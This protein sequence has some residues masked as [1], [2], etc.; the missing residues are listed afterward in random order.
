MSVIINPDATMIN[1][2]TSEDL[3]NS[4]KIVTQPLS[5]D[6]IILMWQNGVQRVGDA[7]ILLDRDNHTGVQNSETVTY[8]APFTGAQLQT[9]QQFNDSVYLSNIDYDKT[10]TVGAS[11]ADF[12]TINA[13]LNELSRYKQI[14]VKTNDVSNNK[15]KILL[16]S[17]FVAAEQININSVDF[18]WVDIVSEDAEVV[19]SRA[20]LTTKIGRWYPFIRC[21]SGTIPSIKTLFSM[22]G[23]GTATERVALY[24]INAVGF[25]ESG[26]GFKNSGERN[27]DITQC[28]VLNCSSGIFTGAGV[29]NFRPATGS[30]VFMQ[31]A[32]VSGSVTGMSCSTGAVVAAENLVATNCSDTAV[33]VQG[34]VSI[35]LTSANLSNAGVY[36]LRAYSA[37]NTNA[38]GLTANNCA[39]GIYAENGAVV[40]AQSATI[41]GSTIAGLIAVNSATINAKSATVTDNQVGIIADA[42]GTVV[43]TG[44]TVTGSTAQ[45]LAAQNGGTI[46]A[47]GV[48]YRRTVGVDTSTDATV[49][50]SGTII[51]IGSTGG[52]NQKTDVATDKGII[53]KGIRSK[54]S[55]QAVVAISTSSIV[56]TH[57]LGATPSVVTVSPNGDIGSGVRWWVGVRTATTF[58]ITTSAALAAA[59][60][61]YWSAEI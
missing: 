38:N 49:T 45:G 56:V 44:A 16:K 34:G 13:A 30:K 4:G 31:Y 25:I 8:T 9:Q 24:M 28:S 12:T 20:A 1:T 51:A 54:N 3:E 58:T 42:G 7:S 22:D 60:L 52:V 39:Y 14:Y 36:G 10:V 18:G 48:N 55:G 61:F 26:A 41:T 23:T 5:G 53:I 6:E 27:C 19:I 11:G 43:A 29:L 46:V 32:D 37:S 50:N 35:D 21:K 2:L 47:N 15:A 17:G 57:N 40:D 59:T 33:S